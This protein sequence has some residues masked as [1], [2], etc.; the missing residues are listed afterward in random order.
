MLVIRS[1]AITLACSAAFGC[2][3]F[4]PVPLKD[5]PITLNVRGTV[6]SAETGLP[7]AA[8]S[9]TVELRLG[10]GVGDFLEVSFVRGA[11]TDSAG[12][13][14]ISGIHNVK[15]GPGAPDWYLVAGRQHV[16]PDGITAR[17]SDPVAIL[18]GDEC[19]TSC[20]INFKLP[21]GE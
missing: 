9:A 10:A 8:D 21:G 20:V 4:G 14:H 16:A 18:I 7:L 17:R 12:R 11:P 13:Y 6:V 1:T 5:Q 15:T 19:T 2:T 3:D